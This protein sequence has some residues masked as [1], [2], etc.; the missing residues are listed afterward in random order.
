MSTAVAVVLT[1][2][3]LVAAACGSGSEGSTDSDTATTS[4]L[5]C[6]SLPTGL[7]PQ[8][9]S[10]PQTVHVTLSIK[11]DSFA[12]LL[13]ADALGELEQENVSIEYVNLKAA[14]QIQVLGSGDVDVAL[15]APSA[16]LF[17]AMERDLGMKIV[18][19][20]HVPVADDHSGLWVS[21]DLVEDGE[22][23]VEALKASVIA[24]PTGPGSS[25]SYAIIDALSPYG[26]SAADLQ[27]QQMPA[28]DTIIALENGAIDA[29]WLLS[30]VWLEAAKNPDLTFIAG[31]PE[32]VSLGAVVFSRAFIEDRC[33]VGQ[34]LIRAMG[35][36]VRDHLQGDYYADPE[37]L[38]AMAEATEVPVDSLQSNPHPGFDP[39]LT[40][41][42]DLMQALQE[43]YAQQDVLA[44]TG[45]LTDDQ[46]L[47]LRF[48]EAALS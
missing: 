20:T 34:A 25:T 33:E 4:D 13:M 22:L 32:G 45:Q 3:A 46:V 36:T 16:G 17:N 37:V 23:D 24:T 5:P 21:Q 12:P 48:V 31:Q 19:P 26:V 27:F 11:T 35:R 38:A 7:D 42:P 44:Y 41:E 8:P 1:V 2:L 47:D 39:D 18:A 43:L 14:D 30:P 40:V 6:S 10:T 9:L 15:T 29:A 28:T